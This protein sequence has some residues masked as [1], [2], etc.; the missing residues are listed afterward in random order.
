MVLSTGV[1]VKKMGCNRV[2]CLNSHA[3][4]EDICGQTPHIEEV[5]QINSTERRRLGS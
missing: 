1:D 3:V 4:F 2:Q 5:L